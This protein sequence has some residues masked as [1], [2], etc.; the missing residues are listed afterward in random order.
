VHYSTDIIPARRVI[1]V[2][3]RDIGSGQSQVSILEFRQ[4]EAHN[5]FMTRLGSASVTSLWLL[6]IGGVSLSTGKRIPLLFTGCLVHGAQ[7]GLVNPPLK[8]IVAY[9]MIQSAKWVI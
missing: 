2:Q 1:F 5:L 7:P 9:N 8:Y 6:L 4:S 3:S